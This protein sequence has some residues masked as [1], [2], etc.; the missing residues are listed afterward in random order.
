MEMILKLNSGMYKTLY[1]QSSSESLMQPQYLAET[2]KPFGKLTLIG[3]IKWKLKKSEE[4][5]VTWF[6][7]PL[8]K[9]QS[10]KCMILL[11]GY[12]CWLV[13]DSPG[14]VVR[15]WPIEWLEERFC[16]CR[17][18]INYCSCSGANCMGWE[19]LPCEETLAN[20][21]WVWSLS[22]SDKLLMV[23]GFLGLYPGGKSC[24]V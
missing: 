23:D 18:L 2:L 19:L 20:S 21:V 22:G 10:E 9:I 8:S 6:V 5:W 7:A 12:G 4:S 13:D 16:C 11:P 14:P 3:L 15:I 24:L 17:A 1:N